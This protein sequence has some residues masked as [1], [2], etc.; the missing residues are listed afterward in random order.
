M[1][2]TLVLDRVSAP[3]DRPAP[4]S[5]AKPLRDTTVD[6][7]RAWCLTVVVA[8]H[9]LMVGVSVSSHGPVLVNAMESWPWFAPVSWIVQIMPLFVVLGGFSSH[10]QWTRMRSRGVPPGVYVAQRM[11]RLLRPAVVAVTGVVVALAALATAGVPADLVATAGFRLSQPLWFLGVYILC[12]ALVPL[13]AAAHRR[14]PVVTLTALA[15]A[16]VA[17]DV[18]RLSTGVTAIGFANLLFVWLLIQQL[19]FWLADGHVG[20]LGRRALGALAVV[21][22]VVLAV[23]SATGVYSFDMLA[24]LNPPTLALVLLGVAQLALF[25]LARPALARLQHIRV[26]AMVVEAVNARAMTIYLWHMLVLIALAG[27]LLLSGARLPVPL[28][29]DWWLSRPLWLIAVVGGVTAVVALAGR[30]EVRRPREGG[31]GAVA[32]GGGAG[33]VSVGA[34]MGVQAAT[35]YASAALGAAGVLILLLT[36]F[37]P[38]GGVLGVALLAGALRLLR[39]I[40]SSG[41]R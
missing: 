16:V 7:A 1:S 14:A 32:G 27:A 26:L 8:L 34:R 18:V 3:V 15:G 37:S 9:A 23:L 6:L 29:A 22:F 20:R 31:G 33:R 11:E 21:A 41:V 2:T 38:A 28:S 39:A 10:T 25:Q 5:S 35:P 13:M 40:S 4:H 30:A 24:N 36:G 19:G 12:S 17:V